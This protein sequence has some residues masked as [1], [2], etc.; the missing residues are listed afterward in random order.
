MT[1]P[2][3]GAGRWRSPVSLGLAGLLAATQL[4]CALG[5]GNP[6]TVDPLPDIV[7]TAANVAAA[8]IG[9][10]VL[11]PRTRALGSVL[12]ALN[13]VASMV[14]NYTVDGLPYFLQVLPFDIGALV[15]ALA[16]CALQY[17]DLTRASAQRSTS[18]PTEARPPVRPPVRA[19]PLSEQEHQ[20]IE[21]WGDGE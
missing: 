5:S 8:L 6:A 17:R 7:N 18:D 19:T 14:T 11:W 20:V 13:M 2:A 16:L 15:L 9:L 12:A 4:A 21:R 1:E 3:A 10:M